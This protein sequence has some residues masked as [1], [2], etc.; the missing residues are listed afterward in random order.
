MQ[1]IVISK[2][3]RKTTKI[4]SEKVF[5][6][7][8][9]AKMPWLQKICFAVL[10]KLNCYAMLEIGSYHRYEFDKDKLIEN[11]AYQ[12]REILKDVSLPKRIYMGSGDFARFISDE[13]QFRYVSFPADIT[14]NH[15]RQQKIMGITVEVIPW[16]E[17]I[18][19]VPDQR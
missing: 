5:E 18:L 7:N 16:M 2:I 6:F 15:G 19:V 10:K 3:E 9:N 1:K 13:D 4:T 12:R 17:G 14:V 8:P 11:I